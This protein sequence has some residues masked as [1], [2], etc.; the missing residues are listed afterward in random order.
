MFK[1]LSTGLFAFLVLALLSACIPAAQPATS[2]DAAADA[3]VASD[4]VATTETTERGTLRIPHSLFMAG[5]ESLDPASPNVFDYAVTILYDRLVRIDENG[6]VAPDLAVSWAPNEDATEWSFT[7]RDDVTFHN[8]QTLSS[9]DVAYTFER[10]LNPETESPL[11]STLALIERIETPAPNTVVFQL[12]QSHADFPVL[13]VEF[14]ARIIPEG[15]GDTIGTT[16]IGTVR[17]S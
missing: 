8:G 5:K 10:I 1:R 2:T 13:L 6:K 7:L 17:S 3:A 9:A 15:S 4:S 11:A 12:D 16:G 14:T